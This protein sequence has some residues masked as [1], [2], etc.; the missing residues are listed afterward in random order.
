MTDFRRHAPATGRNRAFIFEVLHAVLPADGTVLEIASGTGQHVSHFAS[1]LRELHWL[2]TD[3]DK[4]ALLSIDSWCEGLENVAP[5]QRLDVCEPWPNLCVDALININ[6]I[7]ISP[8]QTCLGLFGGANQ[9]IKPNGILYLYG[10][11]KRGGQH[12]AASNEQ[13]DQSLRSSNPSWG[14]RDIDDV[15]ATA[16]K[17][18]F[19]LDRIIEMPAN[20]LSVVFR[21]RS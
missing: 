1:K 16:E 12:T 3:L 17:N 2:P 18:G 15:T 8:W 13:F 20:N 21:K 10:P 4:A 11:F 9:V 14:V 7:H 6:M 19:D 5:A